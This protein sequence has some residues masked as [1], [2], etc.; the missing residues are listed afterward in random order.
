MN[1]SYRK[2]KESKPLAKHDSMKNTNQ[3]KAKYKHKYYP[4][5][6]LEKGVNTSKVLFIASK[7][8]TTVSNKDIRYQY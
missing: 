2:I 7:Y 6:I 1:I 5:K 8:I 3:I 4:C